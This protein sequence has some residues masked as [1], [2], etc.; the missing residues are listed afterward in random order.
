MRKPGKGDTLAKFGILGVGGAGIG[1]TIQN[2]AERD[3]RI[4][5]EI[6]KAKEDDASYDN[7]I[8][9]MKAK[10]EHAREMRKKVAKK[11]LKGKKN[12]Q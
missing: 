9:A 1:G 11:K 12:E 6:R 2:Q 5:E 4:K 10:H 8:K 3:K 7:K